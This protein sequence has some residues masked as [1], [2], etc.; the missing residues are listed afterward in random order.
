MQLIQFSKLDKD[1]HFKYNLKS[2]N[3]FEQYFVCV[4]TSV[5][6]FVKLCTSAV[7]TAA[8]QERSIVPVYTG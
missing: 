4:L 2:L 6:V 5:R 8:Q 7:G 1:V 3:S